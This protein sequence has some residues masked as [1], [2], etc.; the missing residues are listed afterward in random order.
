VGLWVPFLQS[1]DQ[2]LNQA[3]TQGVGYQLDSGWTALASPDHMHIARSTRGRAFACTNISFS[4]CTSV[5]AHVVLKFYIR[6]HLTLIAL[7]SRF[8][9]STVDPLVRRHRSR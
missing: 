1:S 4:S 9:L 2:L 8:N 6:C 5:Q 3:R 7:V